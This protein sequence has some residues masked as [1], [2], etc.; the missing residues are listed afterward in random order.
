MS[1]RQDHEQVGISLGELRELTRE[2][3]SHAVRDTLITLGIDAG[4]PLE[5]QR[6]FQT[7]RDLRMTKEAVTSRAGKAVVGAALTGVIALFALG[8]KEYLTHL[9]SKP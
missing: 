1:E 6:D 8:V 5:M 9:L 2:T 3:V 7:L 4:N